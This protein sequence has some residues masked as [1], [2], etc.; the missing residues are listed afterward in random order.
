MKKFISCYCLLLV[1]IALSSY[2]FT[3][4]SASSTESTDVQTVRTYQFPK[5][6]SIGGL[7]TV[8]ANLGAGK[9]AWKAATQIGIAQGR[10]ALSVPKDKALML[11]LNTYAWQHPERLSE[12]GTPCMESLKANFR[13]M[14]DDD[15]INGCDKLLKFVHVL[16]DLE[17]LDLDGSDATDEGV[18]SLKGMP[19]LK[20]ISALGCPIRGYSF[21]ELSSMP[22]LMRLSFARNPILMENLKYLSGIPKLKMLRLDDVKLTEEGMKYVA[23]CGNLERLVIPRNR[24][25]RDSC[26]PYLLSLKKLKSVD[27]KRTSISIHGI[28]ALAPLKLQSILLPRATYSTTQWR[29]MQEALGKTFLSVDNGKGGGVG[30]DANAILAPL[31]ELK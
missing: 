30:P 29:E 3:P 20:V 28:E 31:P 12:I 19:K 15:K 7:L 22:E 14:D 8:P 13:M 26:V 27:L 17:Y 21:K 6:H 25:L 4:D 11:E 24:D 1:I 9:E 2:L 5:D 18:K 16:Q 10:V 23:K